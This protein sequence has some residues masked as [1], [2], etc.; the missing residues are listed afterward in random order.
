[1]TTTTITF[2]KADLIRTLKCLIQFAAK[3]DVRY[4]LK[5]VY[6]KVSG[7]QVTLVATNGQFLSDVV[8]STI[9]L[10]QSDC[11]FLIERD[12]INQLLK[13]LRPARLGSKEEDTERITLEVVRDDSPVD[14]SV[15]TSVTAVGC[16]TGARTPLEVV[17][18]NY[19]D[20]Q[21][22]YTSKREA[23]EAW[24]IGINLAAAMFKALSVFQ[25]KGAQG[26]SIEF[27]G[28]NTVAM[29]TLPGP[30]SAGTVVSVRAGIMPC[31]V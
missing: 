10:V 20:Y 28:T 15:R 30:L 5:G 9:E 26:A 11:E 17:P 29:L 1:M 25:H 19:P 31:R 4:Y 14:G 16:Q 8:L 18:C 13:V 23:V 12:S 21:R 24:G 6:F 27:T 2:N 3:Q 22:I 7:D